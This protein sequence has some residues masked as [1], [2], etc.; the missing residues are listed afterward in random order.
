MNNQILFYLG[1]GI[2]VVMG[3]TSIVLFFKFNIVHI[4]G[5]LFGF[6]EKKAIKSIRMNAASGNKGQGSTIPQPKANARQ[7]NNHSDYQRANVRAGAKAKSADETTV[8]NTTPTMQPNYVAVGDTAET[9][10]LTKTAELF[11]FELKIDE[12]YVHAD[13]SNFS[14][15]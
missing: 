7:R 9:E 12:V 10:V 6:N 3:I 14:H 13:V 1:L 15:V 4:I 5:D 2:A 8:L 11:R